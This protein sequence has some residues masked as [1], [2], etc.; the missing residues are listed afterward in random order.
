M[1][2]FWWIVDCSWLVRVV[3]RACR[4]ASFSGLGGIG[5]AMGGVDGMGRGMSRGELRRSGVC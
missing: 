2:V 1:A 3:E 5:G 4:S